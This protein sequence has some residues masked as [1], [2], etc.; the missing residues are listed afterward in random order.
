MPLA[1]PFMSRT[2]CAT[3]GLL[4]LTGAASAQETGAGEDTRLCSNIFCRLFAPAPP[5]Q[6]ETAAEVPPAVDEQVETVK[7]KPRKKVATRPRAAVPRQ[8][9]RKRVAPEAPDP[10][11]TA[12]A[13]APAAMPGASAA[14]SGAGSSRPAVQSAARSSGKSADVEGRAALEKAAQDQ[15]DRRIDQNARRATRSMCDRCLGPVPTFTYEKKGT[16]GQGGGT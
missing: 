3:L 4:L 12:S 8:A 7:P 5:I 14:P 9:S 15:F 6:A 11:A 1:V 16:A 13:P 10:S 2:V